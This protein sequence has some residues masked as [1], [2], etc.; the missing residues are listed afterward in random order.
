[1]SEYT[2]MQ[3]LRRPARLSTTTVV[4][5]TSMVSFTAFSIFLENEYHLGANL[6]AQIGLTNPAICG[7]D[8]CHLNLHKTFAMSV[9]FI[10]WTGPLLTYFMEVPTGVVD[11]ESGKESP[12]FIMLHLN[13]S[14]SDQF[15][16]PNI[17][18]HSCRVI[19]SFLRVVLKLLTQCPRLRLEAPRSS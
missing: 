12:D 17:L 8:V 5:C 15:V 9:P 2:L 10:N 3:L 19:L 16:L 11:L 14:S 6:N 18:P 7:G 4:K 1:M 13:A